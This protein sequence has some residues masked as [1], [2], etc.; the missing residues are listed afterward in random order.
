MIKGCAILS[1]FIN[2][3]KHE[4]NQYSDDKITRS[5]QLDV[6]TRW[7]SSYKMLETFNAHRTLIIE[8][9]RKKSI[10]NLTKKQQLRLTSL[11][12]TSDCWFTV[13]LLV[14][15]LKPFYA[16]TKAI[17]ASNYPTVGI[18]FFILRRLD[19][20]FLSIVKP[21]DDT[22]FNNMKECLLDKMNYYNLIKDP[23]QTRT[24]MVRLKLKCSG[25]LY[26]KN[27]P[28]HMFSSMDISIHMQYP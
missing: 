1:S 7:N 27:H 8:L 16:A 24:I 19:K 13:E 21:T 9:F 6:R 20:D 22:L 10:L 26:K 2:K 3:A 18:T 23:S 25:I 17:S 14:K 5:L 12:F 11:E 4:F 28:F 15:V